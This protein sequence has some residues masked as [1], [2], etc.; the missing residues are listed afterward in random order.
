MG[1]SVRGGE[2]VTAAGAGDDGQGIDRPPV[3]GLFRRGR[4]VAR[5]VGDV[6]RMDLEDAPVA[7]DRQQPRRPRLNSLCPQTSCPSVAYWQSS[8][9]SR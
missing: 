8:F 3:L 7:P 4:A 9:P 2:F 1:G 5:K 6:D